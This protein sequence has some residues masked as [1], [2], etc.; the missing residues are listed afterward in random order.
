MRL[1]GA[2]APILLVLSTGHVVAADPCS[3]TV[4][5]IQRLATALAADTHP[6]A[7]RIGLLQRRAGLLADRG[8]YDLALADYDELLRLQPERAD[9][10]LQRGML[11]AHQ[12]HYQR[13]IDDFDE[14]IRLQPT[15]AEA[16]LQRGEVQYEVRPEKSYKILD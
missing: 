2:I 12:A 4:P 7:E 5:A 1:T 16:H 9:A 8:R 11:W 14:A 10:Y 6:M 13:A 15:S 3:I